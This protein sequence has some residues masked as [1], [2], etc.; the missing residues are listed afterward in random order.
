MGLVLLAAHRGKEG[1]GFVACR[2]NLWPAV[3][4]F[5]CALAVRIRP[6]AVARAALPLLSSLLRPSS[7]LATPAFLCVRVGARRLFPRVPSLGLTVAR[8]GL[9]RDA[10]AVVQTPPAGEQ[11]ASSGCSSFPPASPGRPSCSSV[12]GHWPGGG[13]PERKQRA[14]RWRCRGEEG[15]WGSR[16]GCCLPSC[17]SPSP[18]PF[19][20]SLLPGA[21][22]RTRRPEDSGANLGGCELT[23]VCCAAWG[24]SNSPAFP[25]ALLL[26][27]FPFSS[28]ITPSHPRLLSFAA[29]PIP[30]RHSLS[31]PS[32]R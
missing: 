1:S 28:V 10:A 31:P 2:P 19:L 26:P 12:A 25:P 29:P 6:L 22:R 14:P 5:D 32:I 23:C 13:H 15:L 3:P 4:T 8:E 20:S 7:L 9:V 27:A 17:A 30:P 11:R 18:A 21:P 24:M 16:V